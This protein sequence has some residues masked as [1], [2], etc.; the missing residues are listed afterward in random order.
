MGSYQ[1][2]VAGTRRA[3]AQQNPD[4]M[5]GY[6]RA[7]RRSLEWLYD[8]Q[9]KQAALELFQRNVPNSTPQAAATAYDVLLDPQTGFTR[10]ARLNEAGTR[11]VLALREKY[12]KPTKKLQDVSSYYDARYYDAAFR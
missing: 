10:D 2:L 12:G 7:Y 8:R 6:I 5:T 1:G 4:L 11:T 9:N 3:W